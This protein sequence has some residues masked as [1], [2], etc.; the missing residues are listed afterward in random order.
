MGIQPQVRVG[1]VTGGGGDQACQAIY[2]GV[3]R[4]SG[5]LHCI[6]NILPHSL[7]SLTSPRSLQRAS[8]SK[9]SLDHI[10]SLLKALQ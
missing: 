6:A 2:K 9:M 10:S 5:R 4:A 1:G 7:T 3:P 8:L